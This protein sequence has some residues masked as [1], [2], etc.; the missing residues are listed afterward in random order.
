MFNIPSCVLF[1]SKEV[2]HPRPVPSYSLPAVEW[3]GSLPRRDLS[4]HDAKPLLT[5]KEANARLIYLGD[6]NALSTKKGRTRPN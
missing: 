5:P 3:A 4:W 1:G 2:H 6:R